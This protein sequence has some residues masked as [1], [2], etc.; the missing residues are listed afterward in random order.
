MAFRF[1]TFAC[2]CFFITLAGYNCAVPQSKNSDMAARE[3]TDQERLTLT[4][5]QRSVE[6]RLPENLRSPEKYK[7]VEIEVASVENP[8]LYAIS[9]EVHHTGSNNEKN[10][11]GTFSLFPADNPGR[12]IVPTQGK[13]SAGGRLILS[14]VLPPEVRESDPLKITTR[15]MKL[16]EE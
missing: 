10:F 2:L 7:F 16:R 4:A 13:L 1:N 11:L 14:L 15:A 9:F 3:E 12:F 5:K 6:Q 8:K